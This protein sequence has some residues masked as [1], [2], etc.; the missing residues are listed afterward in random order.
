MNKIIAVDFD[1][2]ITKAGEYKGFGKYELP[3]EHV[4]DWLQARHEEGCIIV[5]WTCRQEREYADIKSYCKIWQIPFDGINTNRFAPIEILVLKDNSPKIYADL[6][7]DDRSMHPDELTEEGII[8][9]YISSIESYFLFKP[10]I[11]YHNVCRNA[12]S[13]ICKKCQQPGCI[14]AKGKHKEV[15][16]K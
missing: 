1:G 7:L 12:D 6:Y 15:K 16:N 13:K 9:K 11:M 10:E 5:I 14:L 2:T 8:K 4:I 3:N